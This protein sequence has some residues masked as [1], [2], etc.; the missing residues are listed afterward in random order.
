MEDW[1]ESFRL[2][3]RAVELSQHHLFEES[4][5][6]FSN[7]AQAFFNSASK[8]GPISKALNE[9]S[10]V[11][12]SFAKTQN[13]RL[14]MSS[15]NF[16][17]ALRDLELATGIF[18]ASIHFAYLAPY[19]SACATMD[20]ANGLESKDIERFESFRNAVALFEQ[21]KLGIYLKD[22]L[23]PKIHKIDMYLK[24][25]I[26]KALR[27]EGEMLE[28]S[29]AIENAERKYAQYVAANNEYLELASETMMEPGY[30][31]YFI[32]D[33]CSRTLDGAHIVTYT[34]ENTI[35]L[36]NVGLN[37]ARVLKLGHVVTDCIVQAGDSVSY[38]LDSTL[39][40]GRWRVCYED[41]KT[42]KEYSE[43]SISVL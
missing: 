27:A 17:G 10:T 15:G 40:K 5:R 4:L 26:S 23:D 31:E 18:R 16:D 35:E 7:S 36:L 34:S 8:A 30:L 24:L 32:A 20:A 3:K 37:N 33:D 19:V 25:A 13:A 9:Y 2:W 43:A 1:L 14:K 22:D 21:T 42:G 12:D 38:H 29:G 41:E 11:M 39:K 6:N 28:A